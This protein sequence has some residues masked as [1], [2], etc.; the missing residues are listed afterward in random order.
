MLSSKLLELGNLP[1]AS[2]R[3]RQST[4]THSLAKLALAM[5][6]FRCSVGRVGAASVL[7]R[8]TR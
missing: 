3:A 7:A 2:V 6:E 5:V 4:V 1:E 8:F